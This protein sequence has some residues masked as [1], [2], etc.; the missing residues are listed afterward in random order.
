MNIQE[1]REKIAA[2]I[3][4]GELSYETD[5]TGQILFYTEHYHHQ[6]DE[7]IHTNPDPH[8]DDDYG[9]G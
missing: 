2:Q 8:Y 9:R 4:S 1:F 3:L 6:K 7:S 5:N